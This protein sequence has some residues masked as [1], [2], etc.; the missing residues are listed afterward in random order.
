MPQRPVG[1]GISLGFLAALRLVVNTAT[2][3]VAFFLP[4]IA[5][6]LGVPLE[7][8]G[9]LISLRWAA[10]LPTPLV[11]SAMSRGRPRRNLI[12]LALGLFGV[13]A[14]VTAATSVYTGAV[15]GFIAM[16]VAKPVF[17]V[18]SQAYIADRVPYARR[19]RYLGIYELTWAGGLLVGAPFAGWMIRRAGWVSPFWLIGLLLGAGLLMLPRFLDRDTGDV[20]GA[21]GRLRVDRPSMALLT[22]AGLYSAAAELMFVVLG[23]WLEDSFGL[24]LIAAGG[25]AVFIGVAELFGEGATTVFVDHFGKRRSVVAGII[26]AAVGFGAI[27]VARASL[28]AGVAATMVAYFGFELAIVSSIPYATE[29]HP[30]ARGRFLAWLVVGLAVGR[31]VGSAL[32]PRLYTGSGVAAAAL[33]AAALNVV[34]LGVFAGGGIPHSLDD[35]RSVPDSGESNEG[36]S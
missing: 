4:A 11:M 23:A 10:G 30:H 12:G 26:V 33:A 35:R 27:A 6:G 9:D 21:G 28:V 18:S 1:V 5:R 25:V 14:V 13:G 7:R 19:G 24:S 16:G 34:A 22:T 36:E 31:T 15:V 20:H 17:D 3:F 2:R 32:G 8:A 29:I